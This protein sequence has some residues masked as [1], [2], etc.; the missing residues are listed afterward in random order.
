MDVKKAFYMRLYH[1]LFEE[2][3]NIDV[4]GNLKSKSCPILVIFSYFLFLSNY[5]KGN[6]KSHSR[7]YTLV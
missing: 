6:I 1:A 2:E 3:K 4:K 7:T 5:A